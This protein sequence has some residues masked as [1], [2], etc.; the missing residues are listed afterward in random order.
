MGVIDPSTT[1]TAPG[2][3]ARERG[4]ARDDED[5]APRRL[6]AHARERRP[7]TSPRRDVLIETADRRGR[8][9]AP[10][11]RRRGGRRD[12]HHRHARL[13]RHPPSRL[14]VAV[15]QPRR[16]PRAARRRA[17]VAVDDPSARGRLR[18]HPDRPARG[19]RGGDHHGRRLVRRSDPTTASPAPR[20]RPTP[21][22]GCAPCSST[23]STARGPGRRI[24]DR[25]SWPVI[26][27]RGPLTTVASG[28]SRRAGPISTGRRPMGRRPGSS[29]CA[30][31]PTA[32]PRAQARA[33][34][35]TG[36][37]RAPGEDVTLVHRA[38]L[39]DA[40]LDAIAVVRRLGVALAVERDGERRGSP[41]IQQLIDRDIRP[42]PGDR[43][44]ADDARATCSPRCGRRSRC[45]TPPS[46]IASSPG[47]P[48]CRG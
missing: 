25:S 42:G 30:S 32:A 11:P 5:P 13:R 17:S 29:D 2:S 3:S 12:R 26:A 1:V 19:G 39:D 27:A 45:S 36:A 41:P 40:D 4:A 14:D 24:D 20:S 15:P 48:A 44:R 9:R 33:R 10:R 23:P 6:R 18:R 35:P 21:T 37:A 46:S 43:R 22:R 34:S 8:P 16:G 38:A 47:R 7:R 31:M 28:P